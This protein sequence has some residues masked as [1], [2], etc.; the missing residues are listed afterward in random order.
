MIK[1]L[2]VDDQKTVLELLKNYLEKV[3][4]LS[5]IGTAENGQAAIEKVEQL[6]PEIVLMDIEMPIIDGLTATKIITEQFAETKVLILSVHD[7]DVHL[8]QALQVGAKG[9][10]LKN[11]PPEELVKAIYSANKN[12]FQLGP[13]LLEKYLYRLISSQST[14]LEGDRGSTEIETLKGMLEQQAR[15]LESFQRQDLQTKSKS[16]DKNIN[17]L[18]QQYFLLKRDIYALQYGQDKLKKQ[19]DMVQGFFIFLTV[20]FAI[21]ASAAFLSSL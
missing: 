21:V 10:L 9:Y 15:Q 12:Y 8:N 19:I 3:D 1:I 14:V 6:Q 7:S 20:V 11:T 2:I 13:G 17:A 4:G 18:N 5:I 16:K